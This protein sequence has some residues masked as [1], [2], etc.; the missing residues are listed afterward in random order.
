MPRFLLGLDMPK[1]PEPKVITKKHLAR[2]ERERIQRR[3]LLFGMGIVVIAV[4]GLIVFGILDQ[5]V[6]FQ[7]KP[8]ATV[9]GTKISVGE[10]QR[11][12]QYERMLALQ[13]G[14]ETNVET[15]QR[16]VNKLVENVLISAK[17][18]ELGIEV[19]DA[20]LQ[21]FY[22]E[23]FGYFP[24][25][26]PTSVPTTEIKPTSTLSPIQKTLVSTET[27]V[28]T[29]APTSANAVAAPTE[30]A[31]PSPTETAPVATE[32]V[33]LTPTEYTSE[34]YD[35]DVNSFFN[36]MKSLGIS[37]DVLDEYFKSYLL[38]QK[39]LEKIAADVPAQE[40]MVWARQII[41]SDEKVATEISKLLNSGTKWTEIISKY[42][43]DG[44]NSRDMGWVRRAQINPDLAD[45][46][47]KLE[48]GQTT[49]PVV[50]EFGYQVAQI[51]GKENR[52]LSVSQLAQAKTTA[53]NS[54]L[55]KQRESSKIVENDL[56]NFLPAEA[57]PVS[58]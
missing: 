32:A 6:L 50:T 37:R 14:L 43:T 11:Q 53:F 35:K 33:V 45:A 12:Y 23:S 54:W 5:T 24:Q 28:E 27:V 13:T 18:K 29:V 15:G 10:F 49:D 52:Q 21:K 1:S 16:V 39:V 3:I 31:A 2:V 38:R 4:V 55:Q 17:A 58:N 20:D 9:N 48:I 46:M 44:S 47:F 51:L 40:D 22:Q 34:N 26:T 7:Y 25:G 56:T 30:T 41:V 19:T 57:T 42:D 8:V 36:N